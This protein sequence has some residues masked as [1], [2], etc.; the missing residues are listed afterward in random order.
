MHS[1]KRQVNVIAPIIHAHGVNCLPYAI[2]PNCFDQLG[3]LICGSGSSR[4]FQSSS[5]PLG[6]RSA[7]IAG[8]KVSKLDLSI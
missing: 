6:R 8:R 3:D 4:S 2:S 7:K 1:I 5:V